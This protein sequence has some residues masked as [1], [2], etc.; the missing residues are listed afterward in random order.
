VY[1]FK[2]TILLPVVGMAL[3]LGGC[4]MV[5][6]DDGY[7]YSA[8]GPYAVGPYGERYVTADGVVAVYDRSPGVYRVSSYPGLYWWNHYYYRVRDGRWQRSRHRNGPWVYRPTAGVPFAS[9]VHRNEHRYYRTRDTDW[10]AYRTA[11]SLRRDHWRHDDRRNSGHHE[12]HNGITRRMKVER[13]GIPPDQTVTARA[14][15]DRRQRQ[16]WQRQE[17]AA[18]FKAD[19]AQR[20]AAA[21]APRTNRMGRREEIGFPFDRS[22]PPRKHADRT[23]DRRSRPAYNPLNAMRSE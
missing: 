21:G 12:H 18:V 7:Y 22:Q 19:R 5:P 20:R 8:Y 17:A 6:V 11:D 1:K 23:G 3:A 16:L 2:S 4:A 9:R 10:W 14:D 15:R 13:R